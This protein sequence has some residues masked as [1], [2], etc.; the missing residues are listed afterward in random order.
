MSY[1]KNEY[2]TELFNSNKL[3]FKNIKLGEFNIDIKTQ[4]KEGEYILYWACNPPNYMSS[5]SGSGL[6]FNNPDIAFENTSNIGLVKVINGII[7]IN[8]SFPNSFYINFG[9][10]LIEPT[11]FYK[12][13]NYDNDLEFDNTVHIINLNNRIPY[14]GKY[15][16]DNKGVM[17]YYTNNSCINLENQESI[18]RKTA[19]PNKNI[20]PSNFWGFKKPN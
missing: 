6:P 12:K 11:I 13:Y 15:F 7:S 3:N 18:L 19:Y 17:N 8:I 2:I 4:Y 5:F 16:N 20:M 10:K 14:R 9:K 1:N